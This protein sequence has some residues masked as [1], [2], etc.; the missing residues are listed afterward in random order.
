MK[1][2]DLRSSWL[3]SSNV[4][5]QSYPNLLLKPTSDFAVISTIN[6]T[7]LYFYAL[8]PASAT[9]ET[10]QTPGIF[11]LVLPEPGVETS[12]SLSDATLVLRP[13]VV[14]LGTNMNLVAEYLPLSAT[15][16]RDTI[17]VCYAV[18]VSA[19]MGCYSYLQCISREIGDT[20]DT[21][22]IGECR[23]E[24]PLE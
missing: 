7:Y 18:G 12:L 9:I 22:S 6:K 24:L 2:P 15:A 11:E 4:L 5:G 21:T 23:L 3:T 10:P 16:S 20:W 8:P 19:V 1:G 14:V 13:D 17:T